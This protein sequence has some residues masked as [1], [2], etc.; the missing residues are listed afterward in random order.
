MVLLTPCEKDVLNVSVESVIPKLNT[1]PIVT[2]KS[3]SSYQYADP[4]VAQSMLDQLK[5]FAAEVG[6][7]AAGSG[8]KPTVTNYTVKQA[9]QNI[10][11][12]TNVSFSKG[13]NNLGSV[14]VQRD[15]FDVPLVNGK[16][17]SPDAVDGYLDAHQKL[18][19]HYNAITSTDKQVITVLV[20]AGP[21]SSSSVRFYV[22]TEIGVSGSTALPDCESGIFD[23]GYFIGPPVDGDEGICFNGAG[24]TN[25]NATKE[26]DNALRMSVIDQNASILNDPTFYGWL[27]LSESGEHVSGD[28]LDYIDYPNGDDLVQGDGQRG[29]TWWS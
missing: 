13:M 3:T 19:A 17:E 5:A 6:N 8:N 28:Y 12:L 16:V 11:A 2:D 22:S 21:V 18:L 15:S 29:F 23:K 24:S 27:E 7:A 14:S 1:K 25:T 9:K 4:N 10:E 20:K 26:L